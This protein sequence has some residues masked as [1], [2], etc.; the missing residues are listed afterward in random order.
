MAMVCEPRVARDIRTPRRADRGSHAADRTRRQAVSAFTMGE[1]RNSVHRRR[2]S[3]A[4]AA[5]GVRP[6]VDH[7]P[8]ADG[9]LI[10]R[11][12]GFLSRRE[13]DPD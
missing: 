5:G 7:D 4:C 2:I 1:I 9:A 10:T 13:V 12:G 3:A 8:A 6:Q 11:R